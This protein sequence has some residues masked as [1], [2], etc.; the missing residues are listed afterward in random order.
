[1][2][3]S[4]ILVVDD[5]PD[6]QPLVIQKFR[7]EIKNNQ[8]DFSFAGNG[9]Q[10]LKKI[11]EDDNIE[12]VLADINMPEMDGLTLLAKLKELNNPLLHSVIVSAYGDIKN[13]RTAMNGGAFDFVVKPIDFIDLKI[14]IDKAINNLETLKRALQARDK[15]VVLQSE[16]EEARQLQLSMLPAVLPSI[17]N[18]DIA[19][20]MQT[21][22]EVGGDYYDFSTKDDGSL[23]VCLG[24]ATGH[25][26]K[27]GTIVSMMK[28]L[29]TTNSINKNMEEFFATSNYGLK[30]S[31]LNGM[32]MAFAMLNI[33]SNKIRIAN[34][35]IPPLYIY[36]KDKAEIEE[37]NVNGLPIGALINSG[38]KIYESELA[39]G[40]TILML[41]DGLPELQ[42][43]KK[44]MY[45][46][47]RLKNIFVNNA[48]K[49]SDD[50][51]SCL[52]DEVSNWANGEGLHDDVTFVVIKVK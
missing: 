31:K 37:V 17:P 27:A 50:I 47:D 34:A 9:V 36:R 4:K 13:I 23:N 40:D 16:L 43:D 6:L 39:A 22:T 44:E 45:G 7:K 38:Y 46:Y 11:D 42:N 21:A 30:N 24:D 5:E 14:T 10:A 15:L 52:K 26:M 8:Y 18:L 12:L 20:H 33:N 51:I 35:G 29:F 41:S 48:E 3:A 1:M 2:T 32:M 19:V 49:N 25:G 28:S